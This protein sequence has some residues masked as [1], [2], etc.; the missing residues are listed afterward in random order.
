MP[1]LFCFTTVSFA[2]NHLGHVHAQALD[3]DAVLG[4]VVVGVLE[5]LGRLQQ[6]LG[7]DAAHVG[8][9][10]AGRRAALVV[11]PLVDTGHVKAQLGC[12]DGGN[13]ATGAAA[14]DD[15]IKLFAHDS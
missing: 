7:R 5:V 13:V 3:R 15:H 2:G 12:A 10:A 6:R 9:G 8:T 1:S 4:K 14:D 11:L